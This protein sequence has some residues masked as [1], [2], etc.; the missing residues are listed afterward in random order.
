MCI[1]HSIVVVL[2][3]GDRI[4]KQKIKVK[5][6]DLKFLSNFGFVE[7]EL[8]WTRGENSKQ[9]TKLSKWVQELTSRVC[10]N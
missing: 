2:R 7:K 1:L 9:L 5:C 10:K 8:R 3:H 6:N 4:P